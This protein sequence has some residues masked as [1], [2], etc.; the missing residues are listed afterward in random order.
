MI[1]GAIRARF[2]RLADDSGIW[3]CDFPGAGTIRLTFE[4]TEP[5]AGT[6]PADGTETSHRG[7]TPPTGVL[8]ARSELQASQIQDLSDAIPQIL[9]IKNKAGKELLFKVIIEFGDETG[10]PDT[11]FVT[12][13]NEILKGI[14]T[15]LEF[16]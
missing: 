10:V 6:T 1:D 15:D 9:E 8:V 13:V 16:K 2:V 14:H 4:G 11:E 3:P 5:A 7:Y 12:E